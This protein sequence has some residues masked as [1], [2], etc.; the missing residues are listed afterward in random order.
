MCL[1]SI[2][3]MY[4]LHQAICGFYGSLMQKLAIIYCT[5]VGSFLYLAPTLIAFKMN[6]VFKRTVFILNLFFGWTVVGWIIL[7]KKAISHI[8]V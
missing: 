7:L 1:Q 8:Q 3:L 6:I 4:F 5:L 2:G